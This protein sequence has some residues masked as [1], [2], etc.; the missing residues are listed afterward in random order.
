MPTIKPIKVSPS[1]ASAI[2]AALS[3][4][5][6]T[7]MAH[8]YTEFWDISR[9]AGA[10]EAAC[11]DILNVKD[12]VG[13]KWS[14]TS[15]DRCPNSYKHKRRATT[16]TIERRKSG[17]FLIAISVTEV[18]Q[19]GGGPGRIILTPAQDEAARARFATRYSVVA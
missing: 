8:T 10:A 11:R 6:G 7:A 16:V 1:N 13:A 2:T 18:W 17:W 14:E 3:D 15:G 4:S 19:E 9:I 12:I 5:N